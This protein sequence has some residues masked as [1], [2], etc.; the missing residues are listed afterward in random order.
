MKRIEKYL[1]K[2]ADQIKDLVPGFSE[3]KVYNDTKPGEQ[4]QLDE[5]SDMTEVNDYFGGYPPYVLSEVVIGKGGDSVPPNFPGRIIDITEKDPQNRG[6]THY[7]VLFYAVKG[8]G[9]PLIIRDVHSDFLRVL[10]IDSSI[11]DEA[12]DSQSRYDRH[13]R[14]NPI[15][16]KKRKNP[17]IKKNDTGETTE[18][19]TPAGTI[20]DHMQMYLNSPENPSD[21]PGSEEELFYLADKL[22]ISF[23]LAKSY[24]DKYIV[25][26]KKGERIVLLAKRDKKDKSKDYNP[27]PEG[28]DMGKVEKSIPNNIIE[29]NNKIKEILDDPNL[30]NSD[31]DRV[32]PLFKEVLQ[33]A[34]E[35]GTVSKERANEYFTKAKSM[36]TVGKLAQYVY[37]IMLRG[38]GL[39]VI[40]ASNVVTDIRCALFTGRVAALKKDLSEIEGTM[41]NVIMQLNDQFKDIEQRYTNKEIDNIQAIREMREVLATGLKWGMDRGQISKEHLMDKLITFDVK[42]ETR[43]SVYELLQFIYNTF[44]AGAGL[45]TIKNPHDK[46]VL[47]S[48][49]SNYVMEKFKKEKLDKKKSQGGV[50]KMGNIDMVYR[51]I[52]KEK[53]RGRDLKD[54][55][56]DANDIFGISEYEAMIIAGDVVEMMTTGKKANYDDELER[57]IRLFEDKI[58]DKEERENPYDDGGESEAAFEK[59]LRKGKRI[60]AYFNKKSLDNFAKAMLKEY[61][62]GTGYDQQIMKVA[63]K[64]V[65]VL[66]D[67]ESEFKPAEYKREY[68]KLAKEFEKEGGLRFVRAARYL[69]IENKKNL[70][71]TLN[72]LGGEIRL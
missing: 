53:Q 18:T 71:N 67:K 42:A 43:P 41:A 23:E 57:R 4:L 7:D 1:S 16:P 45:A 17:K 52:A 11:E 8:D 31:I 13:V 5:L 19:T 35:S 9:S 49:Y 64:K 46:A 14:D 33:I 20:F 26:N 28:F 50:S 30:S 60:E 44:L 36:P 39:G 29:L 51:Y 56:S 3:T 22:G 65:S 72:S 54:I 12:I 58:R 24:Y 10:P 21:D 59:A 47:K 69:V 32:I 62:S 37:N 38:L 48:P 70:S 66:V 27:F 34:L 63:M 6:K 61:L 68:N 15:V 2:N 40:R 55:V 25:F